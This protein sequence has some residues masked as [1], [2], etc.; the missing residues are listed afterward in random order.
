MA[1][2]RAGASILDKPSAKESFPIQLFL[3]HDQNDRFRGKRLRLAGY[4]DD[5]DVPPVPAEK[6]RFDAVVSVLKAGAFAG[7]GR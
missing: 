7:D 2:L 1:V 3:I 6:A 4:T 5:P